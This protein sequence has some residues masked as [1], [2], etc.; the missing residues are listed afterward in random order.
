[1]QTLLKCEQVLEKLDFTN[2]Q[3]NS[4]QLIMMNVDDGY[5]CELLTAESISCFVD[6]CCC[7]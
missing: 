5:I 3:V 7:D 4:L 2:K 6:I 1:M